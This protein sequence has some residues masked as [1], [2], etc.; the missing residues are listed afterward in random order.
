MLIVSWL[1]AL[2]CGNY[3]RLHTQQDL[4]NF[5]SAFVK[6]CSVSLTENS[7]ELLVSAVC[8]VYRSSTCIKLN[9]EGEQVVEAVPGS[10]GEG[11]SDWSLGSGC[12]AFFDVV[13]R[14]TVPPVA[15]LEILTDVLCTSVNEPSLSRET[16]VVMRNVL[17]GEQSLPM[18]N[19]L[20]SIM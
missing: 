2:A 3:T 11:A 1:D 20:I 13:A 18:L 15:C 10:R 7:F 17:V 4:L 5:A 8:N 14:Y 9:Q 12:L 19:H 16:W 6:F